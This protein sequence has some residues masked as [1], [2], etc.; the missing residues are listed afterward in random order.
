M[1][2]VLNYGDAV[3]Y[4]CCKSI[5]RVVIK[6]SPV[7]MQRIALKLSV[8]NCKSVDLYRTQVKLIKCIDCLILR[9]FVD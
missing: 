5:S 8:T 2:I 4:K 1:L 9:S 3:Y 7:I 6:K